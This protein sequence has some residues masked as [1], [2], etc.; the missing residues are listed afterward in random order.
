MTGWSDR[1]LGMGRPI[2]R[3]D[4][5]DGV[6]VTAGALALGGGASAAAAA[7]APDPRPR[8]GL[9]GQ[10]NRALGIPHGLRDGTFWATAGTPR[11]TG[12]HYD[13]VVVGAGLSGLSAARFFQ[14]EFGGDARILIL[15]PL[16][17]VGG[18]ARRNEFRAGGRTLVGYGGSQSLE[19][20]ATYS[21]HARA[22]LRDIDIEVRASS[23]TSTPGSRRATAWGAGCTSTP[24]RGGATTSSRSRP[25]T[26]TPRS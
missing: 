8:R 19:S 23:A 11:D 2:T 26:A 13:L 21:W 14:R 12:E 7:A 18:H 22:L 24:R 6:A 5:L 9:R 15:D 16:D 25:A 17:D 3:R 10:T 1:E 4:F 20:P